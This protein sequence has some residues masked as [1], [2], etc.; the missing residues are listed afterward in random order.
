MRARGSEYGPAAA[1]GCVGGMAVLWGLGSG[2]ARRPEPAARGQGTI[3]CRGWPSAPSSPAPQSASRATPPRPGPPRPSSP[4]G[5]PASRGGGRAL[6]AALGA[7]PG[8]AAG[9]RPS[10][11]G[12][13]AA[14]CRC[15]GPRLRGGRGGGAGTRRGGAG[16]RSAPAGVFLD[17]GRLTRCCRSCGCRLGKNCEQRVARPQEIAPEVC[18]ACR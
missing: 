10:P 15:A 7:R 11:A 4:G 18:L 5:A 14:P 3:L 2:P 17:P 9:P 12:R 16:R 1:S 13:G 8:A 6:G